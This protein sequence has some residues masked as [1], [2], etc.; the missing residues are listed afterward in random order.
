METIDSKLMHVE[1]GL[2]A[3]ITRK[4]IGAGKVVFR[5]LGFGFLEK[6]YENALAV[7]LI[8]QGLRVQQQVPI[9]VYY[10]GELVGVFEADL[11]VEG[12]VIVE[13]KAIE[14][15]AKVHEVQLVNYLRATEIEVGLLINFGGTFQV[16]RRLLTNDRKPGLSNPIPNAQKRAM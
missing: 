1:T 6:V 15:L 8:R 11:L 5:E 10:Q 14:T 12:L 16:A 2:H 3:E 7:E 9:R 4:I 13:L